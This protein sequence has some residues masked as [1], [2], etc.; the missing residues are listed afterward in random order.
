MKQ[1]ST[2]IVILFFIFACCNL[3][4]AHAA[5][6]AS[7]KPQLFKTSL[8]SAGIASELIRSAD[9]DFPLSLYIPSLGDSS[10]S[11]GFP[12]G[13]LL[14]GKPFL[15]EIDGVTALVTYTTD[16]KLQVIDGDSRIETISAFGL[17]GCIIGSVFDM[18]G[19]ILENVATLNIL[20]IVA[21]VFNGVISI[22]SCI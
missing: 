12:A 7:I 13:G 15:L 20:G 3:Q 1:K 2:A 14:Q 8:K 5:A 22:L 9:T 10:V 18:V 6:T 19:N 21:S 11:I 17:V 4:P 16:R